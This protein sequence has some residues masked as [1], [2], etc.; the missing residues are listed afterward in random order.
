MILL[1]ITITRSRSY[2]SSIFEF[3]FF[4]QIWVS[5]ITNKND[6]SSTNWF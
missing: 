1:L 3:S 2:L 5:Y 4:C 6:I